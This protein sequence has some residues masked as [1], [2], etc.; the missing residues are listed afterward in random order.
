MSRGGQ[1]VPI[2]SV[3]DSYK[4][5]PKNLPE[6]QKVLEEHLDPQKDKSIGV[7]SIYGQWLPTLLVLDKTWLTNNLSKIFPAEPEHA[8]L[9]KAVW[10][11]YVIYWNPHSIMFR[12]LRDQYASALRR[13][14]KPETSEILFTTPLRNLP[15]ISCCCTAGAS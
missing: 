2:S 6:V 10:D 8:E 3:I 13:I 7:R 11:S 15:C 5:S 14:P 12:L 4:E 1:A 9:L